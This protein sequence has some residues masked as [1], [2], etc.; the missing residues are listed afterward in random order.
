MSVGGFPA[1][2]TQDQRADD[3]DRGHKDASGQ[4]D[5]GQG[6]GVRERSSPGPSEQMGSAVCGSHFRNS[7]RSWF[8][9]SS[10]LPH[11]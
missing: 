3:G 11:I 8:K 10:T 7:A 4:V 9:V 2:G 1:E 6:E 5:E